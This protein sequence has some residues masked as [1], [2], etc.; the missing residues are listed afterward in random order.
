M[1][2]STVQHNLSGLLDLSA[3][4]C[5][6]RKLLPHAVPFG[7]YGIRPEI[8]IH[9]FVH[10]EGQL[11][12]EH[13]RQRP[14][15]HMLRDLCLLPLMMQLM[16]HQPGF[17]SAGWWI[18]HPIITTLVTSTHTANRDIIRSGGTGGV[19]LLFTRCK[20]RAGI[21]LGSSG[22]QHI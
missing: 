1:W 3:A 8:V 5:Q 15:A 4:R 16:M 12:L 21:H 18:D 20:R 19:L 7:R 17:M 6:T 11:A 10:W 22:R 13:A 14:P 2:S 9:S